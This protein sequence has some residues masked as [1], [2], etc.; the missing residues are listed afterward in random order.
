M[1]EVQNDRMNVSDLSNQMANGKVVGGI[2]STVG[3]AIHTVV[4]YKTRITC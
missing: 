1:S 4:S 2:R 3:V